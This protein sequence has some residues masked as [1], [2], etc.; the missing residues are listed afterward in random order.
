MAKKKK[1]SRIG[2]AAKQFLKA[3]RGYDA[4]KNTRYRARRGYDAIRSEEIELSN[5][6]RDKLISAALEFRR[7]NPVV[8]SMSR[9]RKGRHCWERNYSAVKHRRRSSGFK[10]RRGMG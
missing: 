10:D 6:D 3:F 1:P 2:F 4:I 7:N 9:L 8:A 5:Y